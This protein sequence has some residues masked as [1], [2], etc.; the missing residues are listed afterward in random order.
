MAKRQPAIQV[1]QRQPPVSPP[2]VFGKHHLYT[3]FTPPDQNNVFVCDG[4]YFTHV[5]VV[6]VVRDIA[7]TASSIQYKFE[8]GTGIIDVRT[9]VEADERESAQLKRQEIEYVCHVL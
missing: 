5:R 9:Y 2:G 6:G 4:Q 8:D 7:E 1:G 3:H